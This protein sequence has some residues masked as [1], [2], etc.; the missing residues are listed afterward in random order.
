VYATREGGK[1]K[2][3]GRWRRYVGGLSVIAA[4]AALWLAGPGVGAALGAVFAG[5]N[6]ATA[7][8]LR[9]QPPLSYVLVSVFVCQYG[10]GWPPRQNHSDYVVRR[11][12]LLPS[13]PSRRSW[14]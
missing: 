14:R 1:S 5:V 10:S 4:V 13:R 7:V 8:H 9:R 3:P 12:L 2:L 11:V 6:A